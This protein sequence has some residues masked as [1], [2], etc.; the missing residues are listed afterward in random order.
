MNLAIQMMPVTYQDYID[1]SCI[2]YNTGKNNIAIKTLERGIEVF[3]NSKPIY[4]ALMGLYDAIG[5]KVNYNYIKDKI[6][7]RFNSNEQKKTFELLK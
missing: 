1:I 6:E 7:M 5:D 4:M 3:P 2:Y